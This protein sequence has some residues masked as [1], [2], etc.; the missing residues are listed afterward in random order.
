MSETP[1]EITVQDVQKLLTSEEKFLLLDCRE[2]DEFEAARIEGATLIPMG[3]ITSRVD[4]LNDH[5]E[6]KIVVM[7]HLGGRSLRVTHWLRQ[8][9]FPQA[10]NMTGGIDAWSAEIDA[11]VPRY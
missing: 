2:T 11:E 6:G 5:I 9:G 3:Q 1:L 4:E 8:N 10:Q 7:C